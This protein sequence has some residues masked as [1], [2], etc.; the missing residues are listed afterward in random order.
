MGL[1]K[2][3]ILWKST[4]QSLEQTSQKIQAESSLYQLNIHATDHLL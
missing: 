2:P 4:F 3:V 1:P